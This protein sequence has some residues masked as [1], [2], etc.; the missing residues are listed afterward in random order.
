VIETKC[1]SGWYDASN[2][3]LRC[4]SS[5][6]ETK[7]GSGWYDSTKTNLRCQDSVVET[8]CGSDWYNASNTDLRCQSNVIEAKCGTSSWYKISTQR[9]ESNV[10]ETEC[11]NGWYNAANANLRCQESVIETK[12]G[13]GWYDASNTNLRCQSSVVETRCGSGWYDS[14]KTN[15][16]CQDSVIESKCGSDGWYDDASMQFCSGGTIKT[17][18][19]VVIGEQTW[20]AENLNYN[21]AGSKCYSDSETNCNT[22]GRLYNWSTAMALVSSCNSSSCSSQISAKHRGICP[23][24]WHIPSDAEWTTLTDF[25]GGS[26]GTKL[27][28][29]SRWYNCGPSGSG[30]YYLCE[31]EFGF[32][33]L[34]GGYGSSSGNFYDAGSYGDWWSATESDASNAWGRNMGYSNAN[35]GRD[36]YLKAYLFS[37]RC[38]QD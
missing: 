15:L 19:T 4:Q 12:C 9:C 26:A 2:T 18:K 33:A 21:A 31:D 10:I 35:V 17:Y 14:T 34:P 30:S 22:Y 37:V 6:V 24:G 11:G 20:M 28:A 1:G 7:C 16:R 13:S 27:K 38:V 32:S 23:S 25:V 3:N 36:Y 5:V 29:T 8:K